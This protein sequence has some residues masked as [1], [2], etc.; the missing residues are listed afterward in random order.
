MALTEKSGQQK[1]KPTNRPNGFSG[2]VQGTEE[3][4]NRPQPSGVWGGWSRRL[5]DHKQE[6]ELRRNSKNKANTAECRS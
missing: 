2:K 4:K 5:A 6:I 3:F 1:K